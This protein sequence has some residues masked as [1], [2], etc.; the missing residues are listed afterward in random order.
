[1]TDNKSNRQHFS[2]LDSCA[3]AAPEGTYERAKEIV[4]A[5]NELT[6]A[7]LAR[8]KE[9]G[10]AAPNGDQIENVCGAIYGYIRDANILEV[11]A[12]EGFGRHVHGP[13]RDRIIS[14]AAANRDFLRS[15]GAI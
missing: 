7:V 8:A 6:D 5:V 1:M 12:A 3:D 2:N 13:A 9:L 15:V 4:T 11:A 14:Q 10:L